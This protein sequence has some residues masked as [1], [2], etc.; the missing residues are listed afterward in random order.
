L[1][2]TF[3]I[4]K[5]HKYKGYFSMEWDSLGDPYVGTAGLIEKTLQNLS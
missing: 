1:A 4:A 3:E 5:R 2:K